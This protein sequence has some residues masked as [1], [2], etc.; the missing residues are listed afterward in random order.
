[1]KQRVIFG[2][3]FAAIAATTVIL[4]PETRILFLLACGFFGCREMCK[5]LEKLDCRPQLW[6]PLVLLAL[7]ALAYYFEK[8][9]LIFPVC[10]LTVIALYG[11]MI[12]AGKPHAKDV[13][14]T[15][16]VCVYPCAFVLLLLR[17]A[18][19]EELWAPVFLNALLPT[20]VSDTFAMLGGKKFGRRKLSPH[21]SPNKTVEGLFCGLASGA[22]VG[23]AVYYILEAFGLNA[24]SLLVV[25]L[26]ALMASLTGVLGDLAASSIK[27]E[28]GIKDFSNLIPGHGGMLD[29]VDSALFAI[30]TVYLIYSVILN[31]A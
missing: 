28:A 10:V 21:I 16:V 18:V 20:I 14:A 22:L 3:L 24:V 29:R 23:F 17:I 13:P 6:T 8:T 12:L 15:F 26:S 7:G 1:M 5:A 19:N 2:A 30:P 27:R 11:Q 31:V 4:C 25:L 9:Q